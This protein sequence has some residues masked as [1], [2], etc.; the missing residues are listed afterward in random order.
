[1]LSSPGLVD[2][3]LQQK[4]GGTLAAAAAAA[5]AGAPSAAAF[6]LGDVVAIGSRS[7]LR[8]TIR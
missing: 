6:R 2:T 4:F 7:Q 8:G 3:S 1:M 5:A